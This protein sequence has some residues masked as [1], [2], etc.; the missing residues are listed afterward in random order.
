MDSETMELQER[1]I[2]DLQKRQVFQKSKINHD[3]EPLFSAKL[4]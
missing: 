4:M 3:F 2:N 1:E